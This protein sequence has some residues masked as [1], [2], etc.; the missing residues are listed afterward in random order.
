V[1]ALDALLKPLIE[2]RLLEI[3]G[4]DANEVAFG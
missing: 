4:V 1:K 3:A 2:R